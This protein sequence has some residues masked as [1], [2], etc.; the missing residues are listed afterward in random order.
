VD[1]WQAGLLIVTG[2]AAG[3]LNV[4]A[5]GGSMIA[6]PVMIFTGLPG[7]VANGS[8]RIA[9]V[10]QNA[11]AAITFFRRGY[12]DFRLSLTLAACAIPGAIAGA[13]TGVRL[14]GELFNQ[15]LALVM[16]AAMVVMYF[17]KTAVA[18]TDYQP[19][20]RQ[21]IWGHALM[22]VAGF[23]GG[24]IQIGVGFIIMPILNRVMG[25]DLV[26][27]NMYKVMII[28]CYSVVALGIFA[29]QLQIAWIAGVSLAIGNSLGGHFGARF[30]IAKGEKM[31]KWV[32]NFVLI[33]FIFKLLLGG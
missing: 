31:I 2:V 5:G 19:N 12:S 4:M 14:Q 22:V 17:D 3:F 16:I 9:I 11:T 27:T 29:S 15:I 8:N 28:C 18:Q 26:R 24:F 10:A 6:V 1:W 23:W 7:E 21:L 25:F 13:M 30:T 20:R 33:I 32:L